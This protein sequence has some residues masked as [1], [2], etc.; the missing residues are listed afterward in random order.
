[1]TWRAKCRQI[2]RPGSRTFAKCCS[3]ARSRPMSPSSNRARIGWSRSSLVKRNIYP[4]AN[5]VLMPT[6]FCPQCHELIL[7]QP[8]CAACGWQRPR[9]QGDAGALAWQAEL[10]HRL[11]KPRC[12]PVVAGGR[13]CAPTEDGA[14]V[15]LD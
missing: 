10:G 9:T 8:A 12:G 6:I 1:M 2:L 5:I 11:S 7:D 3:M 4:V 13:Y 15:A 14:V